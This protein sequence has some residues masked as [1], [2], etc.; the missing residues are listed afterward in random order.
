MNSCRKKEVNTYPSES[1]WNQK[2]FATTYH[3]FFLYLLT[4]LALFHKRNEHSNSGQVVL[5]DS[6]PSSFLSFVFPNKVT[7]LCLNNSSL[8]L[9]V[10]HMASSMN[11][12]TA[13]CRGRE[14][15]GGSW[16]FLRASECTRC[17]VCL[18]AL[19]GRENYLKTIHG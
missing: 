9:L 13:T 10:C 16:V 6:S 4:S 8:N 5:W 19:S 17:C 12:D 7:I 2:I 15:S 14:G 3:F 18:V 11:L 1:G